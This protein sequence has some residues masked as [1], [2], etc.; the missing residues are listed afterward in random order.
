MKRFLLS[1]CL[2]LGLCAGGRAQVASGDAISY[3]AIAR[4]ALGQIIAERPIGVKVEILQGS[5]EGAAVYS[6]THEAET[7]P[8]GVVNLSIGNGAEPSGAFSDIDWGA[9]TYFLKLS[10]DTEGGKE[11]KEVSTTQIMPVP[12]ALYAKKAG[13][14][15]EQNNND[16]LKFI[17]VPD[18]SQADLHQIFAG[19]MPYNVYDYMGERNQTTSIRIEGNLIY[20]DGQD[21]HLTVEIEG[22]PAGYKREDFYDDLHPQESCSFG[23]YINS[24][25]TN[26]PIGSGNTYDLKM[27]IKN[28]ETNQVVKEYPFKLIPETNE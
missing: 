13:E 16:I 23:R 10:M 19:E 20:L 4:D 12:Y 24:N 5:A 14:I 11:Y 1:V 22:L 28:E 2:C 25:Y 6:E 9:S 26:I 21:Q 17:I 27:V 3:Q 8:T 18:D 7:S 15:E